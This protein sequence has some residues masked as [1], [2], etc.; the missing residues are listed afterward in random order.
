MLLAA[1]NGHIKVCTILAELGVPCDSRARDTGFTPLH[2]AVEFNC[3]ETVHWLLSRKGNAK[4]L[5]SHV[6]SA[7]ID[8]AR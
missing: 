8:Y 1:R 2:A 6:R 7:L 5:H 3:E 4:S